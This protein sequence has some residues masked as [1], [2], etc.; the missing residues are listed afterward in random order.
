MGRM[1]GAVD[2][3]HAGMRHAPDDRGRACARPAA[4]STAG[5]TS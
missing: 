3:Q 5:S 2:L 4:A 1:A